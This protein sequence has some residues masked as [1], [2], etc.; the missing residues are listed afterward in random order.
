MQSPE[1]SCKC[2]EDLSL[3]PNSQVEEPGAGDGVRIRVDD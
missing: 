3:Q 1:S 2:S